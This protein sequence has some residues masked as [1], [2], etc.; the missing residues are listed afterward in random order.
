MEP[1]KREKAG[2]EIGWAKTEQRAMGSVMRESFPG[3]SLGLFVLETPLPL[4][5]HRVKDKKDCS[6]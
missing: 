4:A 3:S 6:P 1:W 5:L 2:I